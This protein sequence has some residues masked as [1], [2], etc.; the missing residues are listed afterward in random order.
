MTTEI[1]KIEAAEFGLEESK[2]AQ[3][4][5]QFRP[6]LDKMIELE[7]EFNEVV[8]LSIDDPATSRK[9]KELR[10]KYVKVRTGTAEIHKQQKAFYLAGGRYVDGW[11]NAQL[12]ASQGIEERLEQ[13]EKHF[14]NMEKQRIEAL[15]AERL[16]Q[17]AQYEGS[18][19][20]GLGTMSD[21]VW[22][23]Y[24]AGVRMAFEQRKEAERRV[25]EERIAREKAEAEERERIRLE[26]ERLKK[27]AEEREAAMKAEREAAEKALADERTKVEAERKAR[28]EAERKERE[29][30]EAEL[31]A[32]RD[33]EEAER[34]RVEAEEKARLLAE[35]KAAAA[36]DR[37]KLAAL[38][39]KFSA[40]E[41]PVLKTEDANAI[42][43][44]IKELQGKLVNFINEQSN[45]I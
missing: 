41:F 24:L 33:A 11:K 44:K 18:E 39:A 9:A 15:R 42:L 13:I 21:D 17:L 26:N 6:M 30:V 7:E 8:Q 34:K 37:E 27:E 22:Q 4:A 40:I 45:T 43:V 10:L 35:K 3:I 25:G 31:K 23:N 2:A 29:R 20:M 14:E 36:P 19:P 16:G 1:V 38:A 5:E 12:F 32:K 28:E